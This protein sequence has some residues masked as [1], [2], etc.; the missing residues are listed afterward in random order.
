MK[1][2]CRHKRIVNV[3]DCLS[4]ECL[5]LQ[6]VRCRCQDLSPSPFSFT[7]FATDTGSIDELGAVAREK[8]Q[9]LFRNIAIGDNELGIGEAVMRCLR[10]ASVSCATPAIALMATVISPA[11][12][13]DRNISPGRLFRRHCHRHVDAGGRALATMSRP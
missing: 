13:S 8:S 6:A 11:S 5:S 7:H 4:G 3:R 9:A 10:T 1:G 2:F 12:S